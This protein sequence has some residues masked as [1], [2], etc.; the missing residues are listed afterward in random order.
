MNIVGSGSNKRGLKGIKVKLMYLNK[1]KEMVLINISW[2]FE[3]DIFIS[4]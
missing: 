3:G 2:K 4:K 1:I